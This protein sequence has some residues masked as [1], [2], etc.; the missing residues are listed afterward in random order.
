MTLPD[1]AVLS[2][3]EMEHS[4]MVEINVKRSTP[5][6]NKS[7]TNVSF[8]NLSTVHVVRCHGLKD[9]T[10]LLFAPNLKVLTVGSSTQVEDIINKEKS[11]NILTE[12]EA[13]TIIPFQKV[14]RFRVYDLPELKS[15]YWGPLPF[16][17]LK[18]FRIDRCP[19]LRKLP[20]DSKSCSSVG[21]ELVI[22]SGE[23][24]WID[25]VE[26]E[27][28]ETKERFPLSIGSSETETVLKILM[29]LSSTFAST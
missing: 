23:Q 4:R 6:L 17:R 15:I 29:E 27:D 2:K 5:S 25:K 11:A 28:E 3:L 19:N 21:E 9:L 12:N 18:K 26:W 14:E 1:M 24:D 10:W 16:P 20:F 8:P 7:P 13:V 22:H